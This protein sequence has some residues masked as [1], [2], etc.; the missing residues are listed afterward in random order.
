MG[1]FVRALVIS[2]PAGKNLIAYRA[3]IS[4]DEFMRLWSKHTG[5]TGRFRQIS[6]DE[7][8]PGTPI[9]KEG[10]DNFA[11]LAEFGYEGRDDPTL[12]YPKDV[13]LPFRNGSYQR[14]ISN[15]YV[16]AWR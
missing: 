2:V 9:G 4:F 1:P 6:Y 16:T 7:M 8:E 11:Y 14:P 12:V 15:F 13:S 10:A 3:H 5:E